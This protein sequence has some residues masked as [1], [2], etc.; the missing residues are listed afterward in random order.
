MAVNFKELVDMT[1]QQA[2]QAIERGDYL[3]I[4]P[5]VS[6]EDKQKIIDRLEILKAIEPD[7]W[8]RA[9]AGRL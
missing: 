6:A 9:V 8:R 1:I 7:K 3:A 5:N 4:G 2:L